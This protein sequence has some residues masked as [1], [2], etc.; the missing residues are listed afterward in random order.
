MRVKPAVLLMVAAL[1]TVLVV[2]GCSGGGETSTDDQ[3]GEQDGLKVGVTAPDFRL[4]NQDQA[5]V[6]V[7]DY[8][9]T[10]NVV[11]VFYPA[12]FTPV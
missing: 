8:K 11:L 9:G 1:A 10:K 2:G 4:K 12:D 5:T 7:S 6:A 3:Y